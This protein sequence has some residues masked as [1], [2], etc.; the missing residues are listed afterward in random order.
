MEIGVDFVG[1]TTPFYCNDGEGNFVLHKRSAKCRDEHG[2]WDP[3]SG[4]LDHGLS[5]EENVLKEVLEEY[6][7]RGEIQE[8]LPAHD[9]FREHNGK[10]THWV[11]VP[12][13]VK[14]ERSEVRNN[15]PEK[16]D[17]IGWFRLDTLPEPLHTGFR[18]TLD[19]YREYFK[20]YE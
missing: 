4:K 8:R 7:C 12:F 9:I 10:K 11:A 3:G 1:V 18:Y 2:H 16:I 14:V 17:E 5:L 15:E 13:F 20:R 6:G 19:R